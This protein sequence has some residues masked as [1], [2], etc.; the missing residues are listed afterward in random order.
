MDYVIN[1]TKKDRNGIETESGKRI[2]DA[3]D[4]FAKKLADKDEKYLKTA[5]AIIVKA[6]CTTHIVKNESEAI[7]MFLFQNNRGKKPSNLEVIKAQFMYNVNLYGGEEQESFLTEVTNRFEKIYKSI[8]SIEYRIDE[9]DVLV[10]ASR[11]FYN[12][13]LESSPLE[14]ISKSL[15]EGNPI[16]F[17]KKFTQ[18]LAV[19]FENLKI[20]FVKDEGKNYYIHSLVTLG[21][22]SIAVPFIIKA[23]KFGLD[24]ETIGN[25]CASLET[26]ILRHRLIGTR[27]D[28][29]QRINEV[30]KG[31][32]ETNKS[33]QPIISQVNM[34]KSTTDW[35][36]GYWNDA[37]LTNS[38]QGK[39]EP[40][41]AKYLLWKYENH[42][43][44]QG[45]SAGY[46]LTRYERIQ[47]PEL[48]HIAPTTEPTKK[49]HGY[50]KYDE[51]FQ[52][53]YHKCPNV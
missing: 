10:Y 50:D 33:I 2:A 44:S 53:Q 6:S 18:E 22:I 45:K 31:F 49:P 40:S 5:I 14:R 15:S 30:F 51:E 46:S 52:K 20:F 4:Y 12:S 37:Q 21:G 38:I 41:T 23:Y 47:L 19:S 24:C 32:T 43:E 3:F 28:I 13:L 16:S 1:Q 48:E 9:D 25:L 7:Q 17:I 36:G 35:W 29:N 42:L 27:A 26:L 39:L 34:L 11:V 8:S